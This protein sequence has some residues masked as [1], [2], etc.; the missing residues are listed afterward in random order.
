MESSISDLHKELDKNIDLNRLSSDTKV[1]ADANNHKEL[2]SLTCSV[3]YNRS[4]CG[5]WYSKVHVEMKKTFRKDFP[6]VSRNIFTNLLNKTTLPLFKFSGF[7]FFRESDFV[8][9]IM[10]SKPCCILYSFSE[11]SFLLI[12]KKKTIKK[13]KFED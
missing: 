1:T 8:C 9:T 2:W 12:K 10:Y 13:L 7:Q 3:Q 11:F 4:V 5:W 6:N